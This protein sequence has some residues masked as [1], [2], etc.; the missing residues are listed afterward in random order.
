MSFLLQCPVCSVDSPD[1][2]RDILMSD[3]GAMR[4]HIDSV[5][6][7]QE[8]DVDDVVDNDDLPF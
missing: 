4:Y 7:P 6:T 3:Y 8:V 1:E 2:A 5:I